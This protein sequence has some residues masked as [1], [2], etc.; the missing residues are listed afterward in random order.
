MNIVK[1]TLYELNHFEEM[2]GLESCCLDDGELHALIEEIL[3]ESTWNNSHSLENH[4]DRHV[5]KQG[6]KFDSNDPKFNSN[7]TIDD[8]KSEAESLTRAPAGKHDDKT[9][10]VIGFKLKPIRYQDVG[11]SERYVK[12]KRFVTP[13]YFPQEAKDGTRYREAVIYVDNDGDDDIISYMI[14]KPSRFFQYVNYLFDEE[15]PENKE[16][17]S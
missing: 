3:D 17:N 5:L 4:F 14:I 15:L 12:I 13:K 10:S 8:Y 9:A 1:D 16:Q 6:E 2:F 7:M 11:R